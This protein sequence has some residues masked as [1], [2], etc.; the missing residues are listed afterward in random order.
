MMY[1]EGHARASLRWVRS[2]DGGRSWLRQAVPDG[3]NE[4]PEGW[5][6]PFCEVPILYRMT[7][8]SGKERIQMFTGTWPIRRAW[9]EDD[10]RTWSALEPL[11]EGTYGGVVVFADMVRLSDGSYLATM[12]DDGRFLRQPPAPRR[13]PKVYVMRSRDGGMSWSDPVVAVEHPVAHL[14]EA[15]LILSP[16][17]RR[18]AMLMRENSRAMNSYISFSDDEGKIWS[19]PRQMPASLTGDRHQEVYTPDGRLLI[20]FRDTG[21]GSPTQGDWVGWVGTFEDLELGREGEYRLRFKDNLKGSDCA[22]PT[23]ERFPDGGFFT[24]TYGH[25]EPGEQPFIVGFHFRLEELDA[26]L[27]EED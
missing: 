12:H 2:E 24:A 19:S 5:K 11:G 10:G 22:Y 3:W 1:L 26:L 25:W 17:G 7:D 4:K 21:A 16:D 15:G 8:P 13:A 6:T 20:S 18:I 9:S 27:D 23:M 14:C